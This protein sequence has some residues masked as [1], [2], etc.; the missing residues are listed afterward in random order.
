MASSIPLD[1]AAWQ[2]QLSQAMQEQLQQQHNQQAQQMAELHQQL[3]AMQ[4]EVHSLRLQPAAA[5]SA[6]PSGQAHLRNELLRVAKKPDIFRGEHG[7]HALNWLQELDMFMQNCEPVPSDSQKITLAKSFLRDEAL[8]W[9]CA[10]E[11][12]VQ[13]AA[14]SRDAELQRLTPAINTWS[15]FQSAVRAYFCPRGAS[16]EARNELHSL[17]QSQ[18]RNL[19]A[20][21][22]RFEAVSRRIE[23]PADQS[24]EAE[25]IATFKAG[26]LDGLVRLS[27]T[28]TRPRTLFQ[29]IQQAHQAESDLRLSGAQAA[30]SRFDASRRSHGSHFN[31]H[32]YGQSRDSHAHRFGGSSYASV[33]RGSSGATRPHGHMWSHSQSASGGAAPMDLSAMAAAAVDASNSVWSSGSERESADDCEGPASRAS[34]TSA[35]PSGSEDRSPL[36]ASEREVVDDSTCASCELNAVQGQRFSKAARCSKCGQHL[37]LRTARAPANECW[38][39]GQPGHL[40]RDCP[41][42]HRQTDGGSGGRRDGGGK[43]RHF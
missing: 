14:A 35:G 32:R 42:P 36:S 21:A 6:P 10:R 43:P 2:Q 3:L 24:I 25:L 8:R 11:V 38:N 7:T 33:S 26:L 18:F 1:V 30:S 17:R 12:E 23:V 13:R 9:W 27:L 5:S 29:A 20:Y 40:S 19:A 41:K 31:S 28:T 15:E 37:Q 4:Q 34:P 39:C 22:D 16:D